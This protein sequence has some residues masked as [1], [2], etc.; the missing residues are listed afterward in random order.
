MQQPGEFIEKVLVPR[1]GSNQTFRS[2]KISKRLDDDIS[3]VLGCFNLTIENGVI[4]QARVAFGGMAAIPMRARQCEQVLEGADWNKHTISLAKAALAEDF[5]PI[6]DFR[7]SKEYRLLTAANMLTRL[8]V[9][10]ESPAVETRVT[11]YV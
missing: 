3:A 9:E 7:A 5:Q 11:A 10:L 6:S 4:S 1:A 8:F 2:Y